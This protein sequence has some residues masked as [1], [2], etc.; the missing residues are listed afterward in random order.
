MQSI[1]TVLLKIDKYNIKH[2]Y[3]II[4]MNFIKNLFTNLNVVD[5][6]TKAIVYTRCSTKAQNTVDHYSLSTQNALAINYCKNNNLTI[7]DTVQEIV[8]GRNISKQKLYDLVNKYQNTNLIIADPSRMS[9]SVSDGH[10]FIELC[11]SRKITIHFTRDNI[12]SDTLQNRKTIM[13]MVYDAHIESSI[14]GKRIK[15]S[16]DIRRSLGS[17]IGQAPYGYKIAHVI[18]NKSGMKLRKL[19]QNPKEF[20]IIKLINYLYF[21]CDINDFYKLLYKITKNNSFKI[22][23]CYDV[24][25]NVIYY[26]NLRYEDIKIILKSNN[27]KYITREWNVLDIAKI[28]KKHKL[29]TPNYEHEHEHHEHEHEHEHEVIMI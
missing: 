25:F 9:R 21:G 29:I 19:M 2:N 23:D 14:I 1:L 12:K 15:S 22:L 7:I 16:I 27:I 11:N 24:E 8:S 13:S 18:D 10:T 4:L 28:I 3:D 20:D 26:G 6:T 17:H 5:N